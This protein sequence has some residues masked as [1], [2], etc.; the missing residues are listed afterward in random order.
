MVQPF[1][2]YCT[3]INV[4]DFTVASVGA[5]VIIN[6]LNEFNDPLEVSGKFWMIKC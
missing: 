5:Q 2:Y 4:K 1:M 6:D 3:C